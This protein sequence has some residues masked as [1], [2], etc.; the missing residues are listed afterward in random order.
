[1]GKQQTDAEAI[2]QWHDYMSR[3]VP[4]VIYPA[5]ASL[6]ECGKIVVAPAEDPNWWMGGF[7]D[8]ESAQTFCNQYGLPFTICDAH[9]D[10]DAAEGGEPNQTTR[11]RP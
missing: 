2:E 4:Q 8:T 1:M 6:A 11:M 5:P 7:N 9:P 10:K 3:K